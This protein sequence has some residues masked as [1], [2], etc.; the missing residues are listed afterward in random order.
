MRC[1]F[2]EEEWKDLAEINN[3]LLAELGQT[4]PKGADS[5]EQ[6][7]VAKMLSLDQCSSPT[8]IAE[9]KG[10]TVDS[11]IFEKGLVGAK[12]IYKITEVADLV[13]IAAYEPVA[14][15][16]PSQSITLEVLLTRFSSF[17]GELTQLVPT[18]TR[19]ECGIHES[20]VMQLD[21]RRASLFA[22]LEARGFQYG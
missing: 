10:F 15:Y 14:G 6:Q 22:A 11:N 2:L 19:I 13:K 16:G 12:K 4:K 17:K 3:A 8:V 20:D 1:A 7:D 18:D 21:N 5:V 9:S